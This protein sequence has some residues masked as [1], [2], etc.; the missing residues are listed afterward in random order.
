M[1]SKLAY[2]VAKRVD[3]YLEALTVS[4]YSVHHHFSSDE[5]D[6]MIPI[7][8]SADPRWTA[9]RGWMKLEKM[10][11]VSVSWVSK[12]SLQPEIWVDTGDP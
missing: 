5:R 7:D 6:Q 12:G 4:R 1:K 3:K 2:E 9:G 11:L 10:Y 8:P